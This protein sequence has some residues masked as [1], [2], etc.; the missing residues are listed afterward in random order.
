MLGNLRDRTDEQRERAELMNVGA[1]V[2]AGKE[3][4]RE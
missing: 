4:R 2:F 1:R 3:G